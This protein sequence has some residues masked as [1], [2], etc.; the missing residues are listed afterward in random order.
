V[1][2]YPSKGGVV[3]SKLAFLAIVITPVITLHVWANIP[4]MRASTYETLYS[5]LLRRKASR[6]LRLMVR[7][8]I[9][10]SPFLVPQL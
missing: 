2:H 9:R 3:L 6:P 7:F 10:L 4:Q 8:V 5:T 1:C